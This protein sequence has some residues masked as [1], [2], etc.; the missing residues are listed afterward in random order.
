MLLLQFFIYSLIFSVPI[1]L[2]YFYC[3]LYLFLIFIYTFLVMYFCS[4]LSLLMHYCYSIFSFIL[5]LIFF[6]Y[7]CFNFPNIFLQFIFV[8]HFL[9]RFFK[10]ILLSK[11]LRLLFLSVRHPIV[12][13]R[14]CRS[15]FP[16]SV[17]VPD[18]A[19]FF[20]R[21]RVYRVYIGVYRLRDTHRECLS[22]VS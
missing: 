2:K 10:R 16:V 4:I 21:G 6:L 5:A 22:I 12:S 19:C 7:F 1:F 3:N 9:P 8:L 13:Y 15:L 17:T 14:P 11:Y 20:M 18:C